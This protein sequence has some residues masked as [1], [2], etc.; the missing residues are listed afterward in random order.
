MLCVTRG[1]RMDGPERDVHRQEGA[2]PGS[3]GKRLDK[4]GEPQVNVARDVDDEL[5]RGLHPAQRD[6]RQHQ[7]AGD[8]GYGDKDQEHPER[9]LQNACDHREG[10]ADDWQPASEQ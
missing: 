1:H 2:P 4:V 3:A 9:L 8:L 7:V 6:C 10:I 5:P